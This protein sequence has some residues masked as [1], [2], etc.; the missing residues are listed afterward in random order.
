MGWGSMAD[1]RGPAV[2]GRHRVA[3]FDLRLQEGAAEKR[4]GIGSR[5]SCRGTL[6]AARD[7][8]AIREHSRHAASRDRDQRRHC[9]APLGGG[10][11]GPHRR[12]LQPVNGGLHAWPALRDRLRRSPR[13][14]GSA[15][16]PVPPTRTQATSTTASRVLA[17]SAGRVVEVVDRYPDQIP[18][19]PGPV[20]LAAA[21]GNH[22]IIR[23]GEGV[24][25]GYAHLKPGSVRV[26]RGQRVRPG[27]VI[28]KLGN[29]GSTTGAHLHFQ[30]MNQPSLLDSDGLP[31]VLG[32]FSLEV[33]FPRSTL[34]S[35]PTSRERRCPSIARWRAAPPQGFTDLDV[36]AFP[37]D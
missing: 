12:S 1:G 33:A 27:E 9:G 8:G 21:D 32:Q 24:F 7:H 22:V 25:A 17:V 5:F 15:R 4:P 26:G 6:R 14:G 13:C 11:V 28:G 36:V 35:R 30:L 29:S 23:L 19:D 2:L 10:H 20:E 3:R 16:A 18:N 31:F 34:S 37:R